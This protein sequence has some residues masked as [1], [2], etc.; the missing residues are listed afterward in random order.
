MLWVGRLVLNSLKPLPA[1][2]PPAFPVPL[3]HG[4]NSISLF[5][6]LPLLNTW[7]ARVQVLRIRPGCEAGR[8]H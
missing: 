7:M 1:N 5:P 8:Q 4:P 6:P 3:H 2:N